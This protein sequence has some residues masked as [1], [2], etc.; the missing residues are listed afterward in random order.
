VVAITA[1]MI[2]EAQRIGRHETFDDGRIVGPDPGGRHGFFGR[3]ARRRELALREENEDD[4]TVS[5]LLD[6]PP[7]DDLVVGVG[8]HRVEH[9][10]LLGSV[11]TEVHA[12]DGNQCDRSHAEPAYV[13]G[14]PPQLGEW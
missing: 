7:T 11:R 14:G 10:G 13:H 3:H 9:L 5:P 4:V 6:H 8:R 1:G 12:R 2:A